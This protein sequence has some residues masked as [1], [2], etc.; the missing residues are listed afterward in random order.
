MGNLS[1]PSISLEVLDLALAIPPRH[2]HVIYYLHGDEKYLF[3]E[4][5]GLGP[6]YE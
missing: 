1:V 3:L 2:C 5:I 6:C 4:G